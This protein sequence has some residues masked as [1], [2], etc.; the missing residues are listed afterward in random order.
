MIYSCNCVT[1]DVDQWQDPGFDPLAEQGEKQFFC[2][3]ESTPVQTCL[4]L[5]PLHVFCVHPNLCAR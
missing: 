5:T 4:C 1:G 3:S 2:P